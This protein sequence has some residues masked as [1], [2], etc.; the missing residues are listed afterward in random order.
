M[1]ILK[2]SKNKQL[3]YTDNIILEYCIKITKTD[4]VN[5]STN[6]CYSDS[7]KN[8]VDLKFFDEN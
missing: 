3:D 2:L 1:N 6:K 7:F 8:F 5:L 4:Y